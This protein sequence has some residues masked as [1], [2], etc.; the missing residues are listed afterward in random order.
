M[1]DTT[2]DNVRTMLEDRAADLR[3][4][5]KADHITAS[6]IDVV[7]DGVKL[8]LGADHEGHLVLLVPWSGNTA[9]PRN[10]AGLTIDRTWLAPKPDADP[11]EWLVLTCRQPHLSG[12][13]L[14]LAAALIVEIRDHPGGASDR[15]IR[16]FLRWRELFSPPSGAVSDTVLTGLLGE[17]VVLE[18]LVGRYGPGA[19]D[20]WLGPDGGRHDFSIGDSHLEVK[21]STAN[22][23]HTCTIH[24]LDQLSS[25]A[26]ETLH[27]AAL[28]FERSESGRSIAALID[29]IRVRGVDPLDL[30]RLTHLLGVDT[31]APECATAFALVE[32]RLFEVIG[33]FPRLIRSSL[34]GG[35]LPAGV[36][37][38]R[39]SIDL[40]A[41][42]TVE[43]AANSWIEGIAERS[44][45]T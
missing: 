34:V 9:L 20:C 35:E 42:G 17:L 10:S 32:Q 39:Y 29:G 33:D 2:L 31:D 16:G 15:C 37:A 28:R 4:N 19:I 44:D 45:E 27:L 14:D 18:T 41:G 5:D 38:V 23:M 12:T 36:S 24:G 11:S 8:Q 1:S 40:P 13:F 43:D 25:L 22:E 6:E 26:G 7:A 3:Q 30:R 21:T